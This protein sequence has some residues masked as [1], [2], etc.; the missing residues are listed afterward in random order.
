MISI[1]SAEISSIR[2]KKLIDT[3][4][5]FSAYLSPLILIF[6]VPS[7]KILR[8]HCFQPIN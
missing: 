5:D 3:T 8:F 2:N 4:F 6:T 7:V 1:F